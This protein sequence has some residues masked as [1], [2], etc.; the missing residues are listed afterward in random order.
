MYNGHQ[1][2]LYIIVWKPSLTVVGRSRLAAVD[3]LHASAVI[4]TNY[5]LS[6]YEAITLRYLLKIEKDAFET[7]SENLLSWALFSEYIKLI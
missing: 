5:I 2:D 7:K 3:K 4:E 1:I 6:W